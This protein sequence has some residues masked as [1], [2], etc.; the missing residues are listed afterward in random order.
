MI[1]RGDWDYEILFSYIL[2]NIRL[3]K[4]KSSNSVKKNWNSLWITLYESLFYN[5][6]FGSFHEVNYILDLFAHRNLVYD[7]LYSSCN[8]EGTLIDQTVGMGEMT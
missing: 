7:G 2:T 6:S 8:A 4:R 3:C 5:S 1:K